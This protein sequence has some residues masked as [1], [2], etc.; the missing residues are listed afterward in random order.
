MSGIASNDARESEHISIQRKVK[1]GFKEF[2]L[3][4]YIHHAIYRY[5]TFNKGGAFVSKQS[6]MI[7]DDTALSLHDMIMG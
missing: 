6:Q 3:A 4:A 1:L 7:Y 2:L 5:V